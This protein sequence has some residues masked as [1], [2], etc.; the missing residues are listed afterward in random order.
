M[1]CVFSFKLNEMSHTHLE[2]QVSTMSLTSLKFT[3]F[4]FIFISNILVA[5]YISLALMEKTWCLQAAKIIS[6]NSH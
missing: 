1:Q 2:I 4:T 3:T 5:Q 6:L